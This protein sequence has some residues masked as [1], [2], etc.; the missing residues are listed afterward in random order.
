MASA[1]VATLRATSLLEEHDVEVEPESGAF[2][3]LTSHARSTTEFTL[4]ALGRHGE[5]LDRIDYR[6]PWARER[7]RR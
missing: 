3:S 1:A 7:E 6:D 4:I 5:E 2:V